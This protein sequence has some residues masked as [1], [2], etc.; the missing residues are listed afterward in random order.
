MGYR[1]QVCI[2]IEKELFETKAY[3]LKEYL[4]DSDSITLSKNIYY[5]FWDGAKWYENYPDVAAINKFVDENFEQTY[6]IRIGEEDN[7]IETSGA[8][9][10]EE[11]QVIREVRCPQE[12]NV[13]LDRVFAPPSVKFMVAAGKKKTKKK[14]RSS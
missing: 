11:A 1:S 12:N 6:F 13:N 8:L 10:A 4:Q 2:A 3:V 5:L 14:K 9:Y 7:D